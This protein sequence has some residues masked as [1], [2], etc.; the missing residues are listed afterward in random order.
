[1]G[2]F[3]LSPCGCAALQSRRAS[4]SHANAARPDRARLSHDSAQLAAVVVLVAESK[5][6]FGWR[7]LVGLA[8]QPQETFRD[9]LVSQSAGRRLSARIWP[10]SRAKQTKLGSDGDEDAQQANKSPLAAA[11]TR[12]DSMALWR[13]HLLS[14]STRL[15]GQCGAQLAEADIA[16][17][18]SPLPVFFFFLG[19]CLPLRLSAASNELPA[20][21][22]DKISISRRW[23]A[24]RRPKMSGQIIDLAP[25]HFR[26]ALFF[27]E[28]SLHSKAETAP[29]QLRRD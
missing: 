21:D 25:L 18:Q 27:E 4:G 26:P 3:F 23:R 22:G 28:I 9:E 16:L 2:S 6:C 5:Q 20:A 15:A 19:H 10:L 11:S 8:R 1:M 29:R 24:Q 13:K 7:P 14:A 17:E 12:L